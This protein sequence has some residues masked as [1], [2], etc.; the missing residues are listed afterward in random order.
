MIGGLILKILIVDDDKEIVQLLEI[1]VRNEGY[2][3]VAAYNGKEA[4]TK[5]N[6]DPD[7]S[8]IILDLMMPEMDGMSVIKEVRKDSDI[9][10]LV[11]SAKTTNMDKIQGLVTGADDYVT[12]PFN[13]LEVMARVKSLLR[14]SQG[15]VIKDQPDVLNVGSLVINKDSHEVKTLKGNVI[16][17]TA[18]EFG[19]LYLLASHP[20]RVFSAD[21]IFERVWQQE[22]VVSA[23]TVMVHVSHLRDKI[24][25]ATGGEK[26]IE[27][28]WGVGYKVEGH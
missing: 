4:L 10:I 21:D 5:L 6:I 16:Q 12:K 28:V 23:K 26:V 7:I 18:L 22:S 20:N 19:I 27:T 13:P 1:Y 9:P 2:E 24:E 14:R 8:L 11:L 15:E 25:A 17:L 3:P